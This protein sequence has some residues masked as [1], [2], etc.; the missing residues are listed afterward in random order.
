MASISKRQSFLSAVLIARKK[1]FDHT[2]PMLHRPNWFFRE[3]N[4][5]CH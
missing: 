5:K 1:D 2:Y 4:I 3:K